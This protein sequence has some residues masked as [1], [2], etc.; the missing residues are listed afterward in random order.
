MS[1]GTTYL[2]LESVFSVTVKKLS[3]EA[4]NA[5]RNNENMKVGTMRMKWFAIKPLNQ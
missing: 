3:A 4:T 1:A 2:E 5:Q